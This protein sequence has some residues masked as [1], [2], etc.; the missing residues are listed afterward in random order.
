[1]K[2]GFRHFFAVHADQLVLPI[3]KDDHGTFMMIAGD[4]DH[5]SQAVAV[6]TGQIGDHQFIFLPN[7]QLVRQQRR[8]IRAFFRR[9]EFI[10]SAERKQHISRIFLPERCRDHSF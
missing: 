8:L 6:K 9:N 5:I 1:M 2:C 3:G 7:L 4:P 10:E